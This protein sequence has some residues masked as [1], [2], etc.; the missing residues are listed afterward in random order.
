VALTYFFRDLG[1][2]ELAIS[3]VM[4]QISGRSRIRVWDAGCAMGQ[5]PFTLAMLLAEALGPRMFAN[6]EIIASDYDKSVIEVLDAAVYADEELQRVP[7]LYFKRYL[8]A[9][10]SEGTHRVAEPIRKAVRS[11]HHDLL[12]FTP[13]CDRLSLIV[14]KNVLLHFNQAER[15]KVFKVF[16]DALEPQGL[17][18]TE[19]TQKLPPEVGHLFSQ[20]TPQCQLFCRTEVPAAIPVSNE[21]AGERRN[22]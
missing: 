22:A 10:G 6:V 1:S 7:E 16:H 19:H 21:T 11:V 5:E 4:P 20:V 14:C 13:V 2:L 18:V 15:I 9:S 8:E 3:H 17:L 12:S